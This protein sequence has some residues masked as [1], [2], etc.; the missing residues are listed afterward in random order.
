PGCV[1]GR[2]KRQ[3]YSDPF[4]RFI[5]DLYAEH[6]GVGLEHFANLVE[7]PRG[8][9]KS[10]LSATP[11]EPSSG[12]RGSTTPDADDG[13]ASRAASITAAN[14]ASVLTAYEGW[15]GGV[16]AFCEP[17]QREP[18]CPTTRVAH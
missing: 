12:D 15:H 4:R 10:W 14:V 5:V 13:Q 3:S 8:T 2:G 9:L 17:G 7:V 16:R 18:R 11:S 1:H 6:S